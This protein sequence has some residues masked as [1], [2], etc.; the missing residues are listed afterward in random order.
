MM[1]FNRSKSLAAILAASVV[2][3]SFGFA[4]TAGAESTSQVSICHWYKQQAMNK[5]TDAA[6]KRYYDCIRD[7]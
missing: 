2:A 7:N 4:N 3:L 6:W 1:S 5:K